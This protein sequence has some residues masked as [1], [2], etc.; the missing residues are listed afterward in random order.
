[1][2]SV[3]EIQNEF[4]DEIDDVA[5]WQ[6]GTYDR[7]FESIF[8]ELSSMYERLKSKDRPISDSELE[9]AITT[10]PL[11]L[12]S[13]AESLNL[14]RTELEVIKFKNA[15]RR[16][17]LMNVFATDPAVSKF[18]ASMKSEMVASE[19]TEYLLLQSAYSLLITRI[20]NKIS[21]SKEF[22]MGAKKVWDSRRS[23][24]KSIPINPTAPDTEAELPDY[25]IGG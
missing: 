25:I 11:G 21:L 14:L 20:E 17:E 18:S 5:S 9:W 15:K 24:E 4:S 10:F 2:K 23:A 19:M 22:I 8:D 7:L 13:A 16:V 1:M 6:A 3:N 12:I